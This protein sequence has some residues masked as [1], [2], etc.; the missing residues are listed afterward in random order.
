M[1]GLVRIDHDLF[2]YRDF[3]SNGSIQVNIG[4]WRLDGHDKAISYWYATTLIGKLVE[5]PTLQEQAKANDTVEAFRNGAYES[6]LNH[7]IVDALE[8]HGDMAEQALRHGAVFKGL[9]NVLV[10]EV[11]R[12]LR[13]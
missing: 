12:R 5:D 4:L 9:A 8:N 2:N 7:A 1:G 6:K 11:F 10:D 13:A 3:L